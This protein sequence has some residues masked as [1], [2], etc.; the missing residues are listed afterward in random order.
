MNHIEKKEILRSQILSV[1]N[2]S[3]I[4]Q[5]DFSLFNDDDVD[6]FETLVSFDNYTNQY[7]SKLSDKL[8]N[9]RNI[10]L[11]A[12]ACFHNI[13]LIPK[14]FFEDKEII[15]I[16]LYARNEKL[17]PVQYFTE[18]IINYMF[19]TCPRCSTEKVIKPFIDQHLKKENVIDVLK[20]DNAFFSSSFKEGAHPCV[21]DIYLPRNMLEDKEIVK[22]LFISHFNLV[23]NNPLIDREL[24][25]NVIDS[26]D[27][28][29]NIPVKFFHDFEL[30][31]NCL[32]KQY[33]YR[34]LKDYELNKII[35]SNVSLLQELTDINPN[36]LCNNAFKISFEIFANLIHKDINNLFYCSQVFQKDE[37][38]L[39]D[40]LTSQDMLTFFEKN[41]V[42][43]FNILYSIYNYYEN[44]IVE[45]KFIIE[46]MAKQDHVI[47]SHID[48]KLVN[49]NQFMAKL[50]FEYGVEYNHEEEQLDAFSDHIDNFGS[51]NNYLESLALE[52]K[53]NKKLKLKEKK[54]RIKV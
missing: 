49:D 8:K 21:S 25:L 29:Q 37:Q 11:K 42:Y 10:V 12:A 38:K 19:I 52:Y 17:I 35:E 16:I 26:E 3:L 7:Y 14:V 31:K 40:F 6:V 20:K 50:F 32:K 22:L 51:F 18:D 28:I 30:I 9:N 34:I 39:Y 46:Q 36:I 5:C 54:T 4:E 48:E 47:F 45:N 2:S 27:V 44:P 43:D 1:N 23:K 13:P 33:N 53:L 41:D 15:K 24:V